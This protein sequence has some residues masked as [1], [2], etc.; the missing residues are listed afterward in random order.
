LL[1]PTIS[2][3]THVDESPLSRGTCATFDWCDTRFHWDADDIRSGNLPKDEMHTRSEAFFNGRVEVFVTACL[4]GKPAFLWLDFDRYI[5]ATA[6]DVRADV[7]EA[8]RFADG[9][10]RMVDEVEWINA[11]QLNVRTADPTAMGSITTGAHQGE[12]N[13]R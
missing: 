1:T 11:T 6:G 13:R 4:D 5:E 10:T 3:A 7:A 9:I 12:V 8:R 2:G